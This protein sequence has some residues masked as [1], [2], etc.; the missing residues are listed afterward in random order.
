MSLSLVVIVVRSRLEIL[1]NLSFGEERVG[2]FL[3]NPSKSRFLTFRFNQPYFPFFSNSPSFSSFS[4]PSPLSLSIHFLLSFTASGRQ[5][6]GREPKRRIDG[7]KI[8]RFEKWNPSL[9]INWKVLL[10][11]IENLRNLLLKP[12]NG[13]TSS[14]FTFLHMQYIVS[15][16][17]SHVPSAYSC[18]LPFSLSTYNSHFHNKGHARKAILRPARTS[19]MSCHIAFAVDV[20][21]GLGHLG[22]G[23]ARGEQCMDNCA[24]IVM[25]SSWSWAG[26]V[27]S[28]HGSLLFPSHAARQAR[29]AGA[30]AVR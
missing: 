12:S 8:F 3:S 2:S 14:I 5:T 16:T 29:R 13:P 11:W 23:H 19:C 22:F 7:A 6:T 24:W 21:P 9:G 30:A 4:I 27:R 1:I 20:A 15:F 26:G 17:L 25:G 10:L 18:S 28:M